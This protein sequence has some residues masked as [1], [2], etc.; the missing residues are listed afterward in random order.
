VEPRHRQRSMHSRK[1]A[2]IGLPPGVHRPTPVAKIR[3][4]WWRC[5]TRRDAPT[6]VRGRRIAC[7]EA[8]TR[9][10]RRRIARRD[11]PTRGPTAAHRLAG[12]ASTNATSNRSLRTPIKEKS[13]RGEV[14]FSLIAAP[15]PNRWEPP[16]LH[17]RRWS[18]RAGKTSPY[19]TAAEGASNNVCGEGPT[20]A[21]VDSATP[22][23]KLQHGSDGDASP[24]AT[25]QHRSDSSASTNV[26]AE[27]PMRLAGGASS[28]VASNRSLRAPIKEKSIGGR[29]TS[30]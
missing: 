22:I 3:C 6:R 2:H 30:P 14:N 11:A 4:G 20:Q 13:I 28:N 15:A 1:P 16:V 26:Y 18:M 8:P 24:V 23:A 19:R 29:S 10:R 12:G 21:H 25:L 27:A 7:R 9:V 5:N 17:H